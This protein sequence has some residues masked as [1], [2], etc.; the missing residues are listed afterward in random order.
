MPNKIVLKEG[1]QEEDVQAVT[2]VLRPTGLTLIPRQFGGQ[3]HLYPKRM[4]GQI[5]TLAEAYRT[6]IAQLPGVKEIKETAVRSFQDI[7]KDTE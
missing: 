7:P 3:L 1:W 6:A 4:M 2:E 5:A